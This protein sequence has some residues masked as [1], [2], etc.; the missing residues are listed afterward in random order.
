MNNNNSL[1]LITMDKSQMNSNLLFH[2]L[3][4]GN[5][6]EMGMYQIIN[7]Q[8]I[9]LLTYNFFLRPPPVKTNKDDYKEERLNDFKDRFKDFDIICLQEM[10]GLFNIRKEKMIKNAVDSGFFYY[11][12]APRP[13]FYSKH[14]IDGGLLIV[15]RFPIIESKFERFDHGALS[16]SICSKGVLFAKI[17]IKNSFIGLFAVHFQASYF[18][19]SH[20]QWDFTIKTRTDQ[21][22][23]LI[24]FIYEKIFNCDKS[25]RNRTTF[26]LVGD[27]NIDYYDNEIQR[28]VCLN[29]LLILLTC[30]NR[31]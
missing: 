8:G 5:L 15:S 19:I 11:C 26:I 24:N 13:S 31:K 2:P 22:E 28:Q 7:R 10:Y 4:K 17:Q 6:S 27:F 30:F 14:L 20:S 3:I 9:K 29:L 21:T 25:E 16:D 12:E 23:F 1:F 18:D